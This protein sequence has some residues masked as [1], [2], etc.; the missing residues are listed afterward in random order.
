MRYF[1]FFTSLLIKRLSDQWRGNSKWLREVWVRYFL[2]KVWM[3]TRLFIWKARAGKQFLASWT[4]HLPQTK[5]RMWGT[6]KDSHPTCCLDCDCDRTP[7]KIPEQSQAK[8]ITICL[9]FLMIISFQCS[10]F[11]FVF[12]NQSSVYFHL[13]PGMGPANWHLTQ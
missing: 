2:I 5:G 6:R 4:L 12:N 3:P 11:C 10:L 8:W 13:H 1:N 7:K 9:P